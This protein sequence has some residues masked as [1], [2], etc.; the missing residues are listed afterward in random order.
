MKMSVFAAALFVSI[1][2]LLPQRLSLGFASNIF[3]PAP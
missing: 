2:K 1:G 3:F